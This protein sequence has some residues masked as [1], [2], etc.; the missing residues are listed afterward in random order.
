MLCPNDADLLIQAA[1]LQVYLGQPEA[2]T[3]DTAR[4]MQINPY[5]PNDYF[6]IAAVASI[7]AGDLEHGS[8]CGLPVTRLRWSTFRPSRRQRMHVKGGTMP[9]GQRLTGTSPP[10]ARGS[11]SET[12]SIHRRRSGTR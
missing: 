11:P 12:S 6:S 4:A 1:M 8:C 5:H 9:D 7:F 3:R 2:A 10:I